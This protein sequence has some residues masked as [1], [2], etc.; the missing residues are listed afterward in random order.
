MNNCSLATLKRFLR[1][2]V[3]ANDKEKHK[4]K[5]ITINEFINLFKN[6]SYKKTEVAKILGVK[7]LALNEY[8]YRNGI[9]WHKEKMIQY[10]ENYKE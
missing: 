5:Y 3:L 2:N 8:C 7:T 1:E 4:L 6:N 10:M 9:P